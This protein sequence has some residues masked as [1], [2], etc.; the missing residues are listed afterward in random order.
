MRNSLKVFLDANILLD[1]CSHKRKYHEQSVRTVEKFLK[2]GAELVASSDSITTVYYVLRKLT[3]DKE[4]SL[5]AV[6]NLSDYITL[7]SFSNE[8][9]KE[10]INLMKADNKFRDLEDTLQYVLAKR[11]GCSLIL[12]ND[13][14]FYSPDI[15]VRT[16][17]EA[18]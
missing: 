5:L 13:K 3:G 18:G 7:A 17:G 6:E 4:L 11:E 12:T 15:D 9:V 8:E 16:S 10:A 1:L 2:S 14:G